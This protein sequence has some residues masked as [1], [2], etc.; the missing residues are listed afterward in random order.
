MS[1]RSRGWLELWV[2]LRFPL[3]GMLAT[4]V[5]LC[6]DYQ[7]GEMVGLRVTRRKRVVAAA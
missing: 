7:F 6:R 1:N 4:F 2:G 5:Q 3:I